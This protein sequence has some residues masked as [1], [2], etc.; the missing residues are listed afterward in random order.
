MHPPPKRNPNWYKKND[1]NVNQIDIKKNWY[2]KND[3]NVT[4]NLMIVWFKPVNFQMM[5][6]IWY[7]ED[8]LNLGFR[9]AQL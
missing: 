4:I 6:N 7:W 8:F 3:Q 2:K 1:Q 5:G 9:P